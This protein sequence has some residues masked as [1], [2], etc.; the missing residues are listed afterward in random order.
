MNLLVARQLTPEAYG[1]RS[2]QQQQQQ[3]QHQ[4]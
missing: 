2:E 4:H 3:H 1:V